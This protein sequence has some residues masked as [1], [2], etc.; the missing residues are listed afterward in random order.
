MMA[1][2]RLLPA[3]MALAMLAGCSKAAAPAETAPETGKS[4][5]T[6]AKAKAKSEAVHKAK[7][8]AKTEASAAPVSPP[9][10]PPAAE[11]PALALV[12]ATADGVALLDLSAALHTWSPWLLALPAGGADAKALVADLAD[13]LER[14]LGVDIRGATT[15][16]VFVRAD[17]LAGAVLL[18]VRGAP[19]GGKPA[20]EKDGVA[21]VS[22]KGPVV[23]AALEQGLAIGTRPAVELLIE[24]AKGK[25]PNAAKGA[26]AK[27]LRAV[28]DA[29]GPGGI[30]AAGSPTRLS[31]PVEELGVPAL[32]WLAFAVGEGGA[33]IVGK[34]TKEQVSATERAI[35]EALDSSERQAAALRDGSAGDP[36]SEL[37]GI[38]AVHANRPFRKHLHVENTGEQLTVRVSG[39]ELLVLVGV[40]YTGVVAAVAIPAFIKYTRRSKTT[41]AIDNLDRLYKDAAV[42]YVTP[43]VD[44]TGA[45]LP[46]SLPPSVGWTPAGSP[47][48][49]KGGKYPG[50]PD[51][52]SDP[53]WRALGFQIDGPH[54]F[55]YKFDAN[56]TVKDGKFTI[57]AS[58]DL[59]CD[60]VWS[61]FER[62]GFADPDAGPGE[63]ALGSSSAF[64][65]DQ[66]TE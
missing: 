21:L 19:A 32:P 51:E 36:G 11:E 49:H 53:T 10:A 29:V 3:L 66:E 9:S 13:I 65:T 60:G 58:A 54:Y 17:K 26:E 52:W 4:P 40:A 25:A 64:Y 35:R 38:L 27:E 22:V 56:P 46:C 24:T 62:Y 8:E 43:R 5:K 12:P 15:A 6:E 37:A 39:N 16:V 7:A 63:C 18:G 45:K 14:R 57:T 44:P 23:A 42:Y 2:R 41:E 31:L 59:D 30:R 33:T 34:G 61:T 20:G 28:L 47:C 1:T 50:G 48:D 55:R